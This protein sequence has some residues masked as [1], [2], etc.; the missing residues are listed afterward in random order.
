MY[1]CACGLFGSFQFISVLID[2][3][4]METET[5]TEG[6][7]RYMIVQKMPGPPVRCVSEV[8]LFLTLVWFGVGEVMGEEGRGEGGRSRK[9]NTI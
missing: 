2:W 7:M 9:G 8:S 1:M 5:E 4:G 3:T 6:W